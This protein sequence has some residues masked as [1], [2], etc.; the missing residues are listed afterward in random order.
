V[1][2]SA[3]WLTSIMEPLDKTE[4]AMKMPSYPVEYLSI[5]KGDQE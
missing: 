2:L 4:S 3:G 1:G 5:E